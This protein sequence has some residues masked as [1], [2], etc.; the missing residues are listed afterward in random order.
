MSRPTVFGQRLEYF[1]ADAFTD[2][3]ERDTETNDSDDAT[4]ALA[5]A[6]TDGGADYDANRHCDIDRTRIR[7]D[8]V[9]THTDRD[10]NA[11]ADSAT[12]VSLFPTDIG[13]DGVRPLTR[14]ES[15]DGAR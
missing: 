12:D 4:D 13:S 5:D 3:D 8:N 15:R 10:D 2:A 6:D 14:G 11:Y 1:V 7:D 9:H